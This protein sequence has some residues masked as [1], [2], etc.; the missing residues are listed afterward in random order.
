MNLLIGILVIAFGTTMAYS[1]EFLARGNVA[2][3]RPVFGE[4]KL[5]THVW[6]YRLIGGVFCALGIL[7]AVGVIEQFGGK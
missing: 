1:A 5:K 3:L 6:M 2:A 7:T 4:T